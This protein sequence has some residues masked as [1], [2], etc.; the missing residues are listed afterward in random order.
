MEYDIVKAYHSLG[1]KINGHHSNPSSLKS[2]IEKYRIESNIYIV[3]GYSTLPYEVVSKFPVGKFGS[4]KTKFIISRLDDLLDSAEQRL[5]IPEL[6][7]D[8]PMEIEC[9]SCRHQHT[10]L[11]DHCKESPI[12]SIP[13]EKYEGY[14]CVSDDSSVWLS[15]GV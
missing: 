9:P 4:S 6:V 2:I 3:G 14:R 13:I 7:S 5:R 12:A 8:N 11:H 15:V 10:G 1:S